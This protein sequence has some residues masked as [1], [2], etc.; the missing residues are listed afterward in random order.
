MSLV[1]TR[2]PAAAAVLRKFGVRID[3]RRIGGIKSGETRTFNVS[4]GR[5]VVIVTQDWTSSRPFTFD[6][7]EGQVLSLECG[8][9]QGYSATLVGL[10]SH[11]RSLLFLREQQQ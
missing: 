1:L 4:P 7:Q 3:G 5:H 6:M 2:R 11:P 8:Y 10:I 9:Q